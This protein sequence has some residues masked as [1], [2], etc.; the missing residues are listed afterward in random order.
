MA[1]LLSSAFELATATET[2]PTAT[3]FASALKFVVFLV[4]TKMRSPETVFMPAPLVFSKEI[5]MVWVFCTQDQM[6]FTPK[7]VEPAIPHKCVAA[8]VRSFASR[9]TLP[10]VAKISVSVTVMPEVPVIFTLFMTTFTAPEINV[11]GEMAMEAAMVTLSMP[12]N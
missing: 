2:R 11:V 6:V 1:E 8:F 3:P 12:P 7:I 10:P 5:P 9:V 4:P